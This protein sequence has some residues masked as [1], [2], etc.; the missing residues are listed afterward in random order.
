MKTLLFNTTYVLRII[1]IVLL[2]IAGI[3]I[4]I[5]VPTNAVH[6]IDFIAQLFLKTLGLFLAVFAYNKLI[7]LRVIKLE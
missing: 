6:D 7:D 4:A 3:A 2:F 5:L 1:L